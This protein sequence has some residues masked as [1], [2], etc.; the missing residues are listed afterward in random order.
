MKQYKERKEKENEADHYLVDN[1]SFNDLGNIPCQNCNGKEHR[2]I[3]R[4]NRKSKIERRR[5]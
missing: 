2:K 1:Y 4:N 3:Y 5:K